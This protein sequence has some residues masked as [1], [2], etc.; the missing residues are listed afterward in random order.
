[1]T[2]TEAGPSEHW[3]SVILATL[4]ARATD[5]PEPES[6]DIERAAVSIVAA[7]MLGVGVEPAEVMRLLSESELDIYM[8]YDPQGKRVLVDV[9]WGDDHFEVSADIGDLA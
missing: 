3:W 4:E 1:M 2:S 8:A 7:T 6:G 5:K 9:D